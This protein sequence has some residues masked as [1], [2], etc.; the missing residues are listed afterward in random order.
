MVDAETHGAAAVLVLLA[1]AR[2]TLDDAIDK[3]TD[4]MTA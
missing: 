4:I 3:A 1:F 2:A